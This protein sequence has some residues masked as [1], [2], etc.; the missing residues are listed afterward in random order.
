MNKIKPF[1]Y[2]DKY[3]GPFDVPNKIN[4]QFPG[5]RDLIF[6]FLKCNTEFDLEDAL[7]YPTR[8]LPDFRRSTSLGCLQFYYRMSLV[9]SG[10]SLVEADR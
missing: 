4:M 7:P 10:S 8:P 9:Q 3:R 6:K 5:T 2:D 1:K